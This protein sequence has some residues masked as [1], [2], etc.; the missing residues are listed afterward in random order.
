MNRS[1]D[2]CP[3]RPVPPTRY[4]LSEELIWKIICGIHQYCQKPI[5]K[6]TREEV[7]RFIVDRTCPICGR[8]FLS[9]LSLATH[10]AIRIFAGVECIDPKENIIDLD[11]LFPSFGKR[12]EKS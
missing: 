12:I 8:V 5:S 9:K 4:F 3:G 11:L 7:R 10:H 6:I 1:I 2:D